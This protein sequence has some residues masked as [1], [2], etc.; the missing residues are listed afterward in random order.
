MKIYKGELDDDE[1]ETNAWS[2]GMIGGQQ[3]VETINPNVEPFKEYF[4]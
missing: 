1:T 3:L 2:L 4:D